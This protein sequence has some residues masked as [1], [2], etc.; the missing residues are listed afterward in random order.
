[1][2]GRRFIDWREAPEFARDLCDTLSSIRETV[3][4]PING[5]SLVEAFYQTDKV[6]IA[7]YH[8]EF[9][10]GGLVD[11]NGKYVILDSNKNCSFIKNHNRKQFE[12]CYDQL[13]ART[14]K[15]LEEILHLDVNCTL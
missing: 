12:Q 14:E 6:V 8:P 5:L 2:R 3:M 15:S 1:M 13:Y 7:A 10:M 11:Y 4:D 9:F